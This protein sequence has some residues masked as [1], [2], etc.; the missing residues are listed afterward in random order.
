LNKIVIAGG[1]GFLGQF[2]ASKFRA[3]GDDVLIISRNK[4]DV[5]WKDRERIIKVLNNAD[6]VINLAGKSVDCRYNERNKR[7]ILNSRVDTTRTI[8]EAILECS[9]PP[10]LWINSSTATIYRHAEDRP[11]TE[12]NGEMGKGF[13]VNV[14]Q[15]WEKAFFDFKLSNV[16]QVALRMAIVLGRQGGVMHPLK[17]LTR[18]GLGGKQGKGNQMF[19]WIHIEDLFRII[20]FLMEH[21]GLNGVINC[22][23]PEPVSNR[24]LMKS[25]GA[26]LHVKV[27]LPTPEWL[28]EIGAVLIRTETELVLKS[29]WVLPDRLLNSGFTFTYPTLASALEEVLN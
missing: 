16:R 9:Q 11:M 1:T 7:D 14:A 4:G 20:L 5:L 12:E 19:S 29:R 6:V 18:L 27:G 24:I 3:K 13:S 25:I 26:A 2:L 15:Q 28:L 8:G 21:E 23:S 17:R 10:K 22:S